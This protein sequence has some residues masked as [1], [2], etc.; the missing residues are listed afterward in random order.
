M[1]IRYFFVADVHHRRHIT[2][3]YCPTDEMIADFFTKPLGGAKF[4]RFRNIIMN[5]AR[6]EHGPVNV[7][8]LMEI[9]QA[10]M[11]RRMD[12]RG[13]YED[14]KKDESTVEAG[15]NKLNDADSQECVGD[16]GKRS[17]SEWAVVRAAH[18]NVRGQQRR[19]TYAE[20]VAE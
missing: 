8:E 2:I 1:N 3:E 11:R 19:P 15:L 14:S 12:A 9:H 17:N 6:D 10:K 13:E 7:D 16:R 4:R 18:K 20:V 5:V